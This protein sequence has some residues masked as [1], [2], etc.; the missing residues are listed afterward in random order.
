MPYQVVIDTNV[1]VSALRSKRGASYRLLMLLGDSRWENNVSSALLYEYEE[2]ARAFRAELGLTD[3]EIET[4][5]D[6][7]AARSN[8]Q[9]IYFSWR[10]SLPDPDD[11]FLLDLA[12][13]I[14]CDC[15]V[16]YNVADFI[17]ARDFGI[18]VLR[19]PE[20]LRLIGEIK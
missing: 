13:G 3:E 9:I 18:R 17:R 20:F 6:L 4:A 7:I 8:H 16:T 11:E 10:P 2:K 19:P 12:A 14:R 15:L 1:F 5:L